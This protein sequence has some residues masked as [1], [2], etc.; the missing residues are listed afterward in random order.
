VHLYSACCVCCVIFKYLSAVWR[1]EDLHNCAVS[2]T[3]DGV[4]V[5]R[6]RLCIDTKTINSSKCSFITAR[7][8]AAAA[9][10][11]RSPLSSDQPAPPHARSVD[12]SDPG[13]ISTGRQH[14]ALVVQSCPVIGS[15]PPATP[16]SRPIPSP[17]GQSSGSTGGAPAR[18]PRDSCSAS[19]DRRRRTRARIT[20]DEAALRCW[21]CQAIRAAVAA[22]AAAHTS[23][24]QSPSTSRL[25]AKTTIAQATRATSTMDSVA[26]RLAA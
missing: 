13:S 7:H 25:A 22:A 9:T 24:V 3:R 23:A 26:A 20:L 17:P 10:A 4:A 16:V 18:P 21:R 11:A 1:N 8:H 14:G 6:V 2:N 15:P 5:R 19:M 12:T